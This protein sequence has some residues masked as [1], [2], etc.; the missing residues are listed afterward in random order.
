MQGLKNKFVFLTLLLLTSLCCKAQSNVYSLSVYAGGTSYRELCSFDF[1]FP[2]HKYRLT[3]RSWREDANGF[4]IMD[5][6]HKK[7]PGDVLRRSLEVECGSES[8]IVPFD[9][10]PPKKARS[11]DSLPVTKGS[12]DLAQLV[13]QCA[14]NRGGRVTT[15]TLPV[16]QASWARQSREVQDILV[17]DGDHFA[18]VQKRLEQVYGK[19]D[20]G[21]S[22][23]APIGN[24]RSL[25]YT[26]QLIGVVLNLISDSRQTIVSVIGK[27]KP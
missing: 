16:V 3:E 14:T 5:I 27:Q 26:P 18:E 9:S 23:S 20:A 8:F 11:G 13:M 19:P 15:N 6:R 2:P 7:A 1:P 25:T 24:G 10:A 22:S 4:T 17:V 21:I 12:G